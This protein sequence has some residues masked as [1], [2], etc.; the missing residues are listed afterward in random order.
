MGG[1]R[2]GNTLSPQPLADGFEQSITQADS[3]A[4]R[5]R[6][7]SERVAKQAAAMATLHKTGRKLE[8]LEAE[9]TRLAQNA[10]AASRDAGNRPGQGL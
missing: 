2:W 4:D 8:Y 1:P 6:R 9:Q 10:G 7:E 5:L 3:H